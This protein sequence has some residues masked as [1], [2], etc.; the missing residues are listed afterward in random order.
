[1]IV[2]P[3]LDIFLNEIILDYFSQF[4]VN[5]GLFN[6]AKIGH[7]DLVEFFISKGA[8]SCKWARDWSM[9]A[10]VDDGHKELV[11]FFISKGTYDWNYCM[12]LATFNGHKEL[13]ELFISKGANDFW[14]KGKVCAALG[15]TELEEFFQQ[16]INERDNN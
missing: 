15:H 3:E 6:A 5:T 12:D 1:M 10:A 7:K 13:V 2:V 9:Y 11:E 16:K 4:D 8:P 14:D